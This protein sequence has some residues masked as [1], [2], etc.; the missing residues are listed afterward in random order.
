MR[1]LPDIGADDDESYTIA[2]SIASFP[3]ALIA[4]IFRTVTVVALD[5]VI[6]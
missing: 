3:R 1:T 6:E 2:P 4:V 5:A